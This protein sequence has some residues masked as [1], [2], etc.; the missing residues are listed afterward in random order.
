MARRIRPLPL[1]ALT[2][3]WVALW[4]NVSWINVVSGLV[5]AAAI[6]VLFP[7]PPLASMVRVHPVGAAHLLARF[8]V[9]LVASSVRVAALVV[10]PRPVGAGAIIE[11]PLTVPDDLRRAVVAEMTSLVPGT[12]VIDLS[13][14]TGVLTLHV[15]DT[16]DEAELARERENVRALERRVVAALGVRG[17]DGPVRPAAGDAGD[18]GAADDID[19]IDEVAADRRRE[20]ERR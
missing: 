20:G 18:A 10:R 1:L 4:G 15:L 3:V 7:L 5:V 6:L 12:V 2:G 8:G 13:A 11:V 9:D 19:D 14:R 17:A 16:T